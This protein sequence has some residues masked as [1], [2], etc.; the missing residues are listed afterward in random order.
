MIYI[1]I[2]HPKGKRPETYSQWGK[3]DAQSLIDFYDLAEDDTTVFDADGNR[4]TSE[5]TFDK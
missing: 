3:E 2:W 5:F 4:V 1:V